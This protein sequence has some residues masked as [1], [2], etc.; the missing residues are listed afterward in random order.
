MLFRS[1]FRPTDS[2]RT[3]PPKSLLLS[4]EQITNSFPAFLLKQLFGTLDQAVRSSAHPD[5]AALRS[6]CDD[7][8]RISSASNNASPGTYASPID[9]LR[10]FLGTGVLNSNYLAVTLLSSAARLSASNGVNA[11]LA[12]VGGR[13]TTNLTLRVRADSFT[14]FCT[15][16]DTLGPSVTNKNL[17]DATGQPF[18]FPDAFSVLPGSLVQVY[19]YT[20]L[21]NAACPGDDLEVISLSLIGVPVASDPDSDGDLLIDTWAALFASGRGSN[22]F[23]DDDGDGYQNLQE[24]FEGSDASDFFGV[25]GAVPV[26]MTRPV[27]NVTVQPNGD[28]RLRWAFPMQYAGRLKFNVRA[29]ASVTGPFTNVV[30]DVP[31]VS[32]AFD[33]T[34]P[35]PGPP[36]RFYYVTMALR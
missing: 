9:T 19:G 1:P 18:G 31:Q 12:L 25:P 30:I 13:P 27:I 24:M 23:A 34:I 22:A 15:V 3:N 26:P 20:D 33:V 10:G 4:L 7:I 16:L 5:I 28:V 6:L 8:Y 11:A 36:A 29:S 35:N 21:T 32:G 17:F 2:S 14:G